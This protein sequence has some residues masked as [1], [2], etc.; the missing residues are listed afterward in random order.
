MHGNGHTPVPRV[1]SRAKLGEGSTQRVSV[2]DGVC[3]APN[4]L[5]TNVHEVSNPDHDLHTYHE[6]MEGVIVRHYQGTLVTITA[7]EFRMGFNI[8]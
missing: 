5:K 4:V 2:C 6:A 8:S 7:V 1:G 3:L